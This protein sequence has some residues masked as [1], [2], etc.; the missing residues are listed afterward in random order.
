MP[1]TKF[2]LEVKRGSACVKIYRT[3][4]KGC[5]SFTLSYWVDGKRNRIAFADFDKAKS[6]ASA[7]ADRLSKG[8]F[9]NAT[10]NREDRATYARAIEILKLTGIPLELAVA[11]FV[12]AS[13]ALSGRPLIDAARFY[14]RRH[15]AQMPRRTVSETI[16]EMIVAKTQDGLSYLAINDLKKLRILA[17]DFQ[18]QISDLS[19]A[20]VDEWLRERDLAGRT[21]NNYRDLV[22]TMFN[23]AKRKK[24]L[25]FDHN[26]IDAVSIAKEGAT[27]IE[28]FSPAEM[29]MILS[30]AEPHLVPFLALGAFAGVRHWEITRLDWVDVK[31]AENHVEIKKGK[32]KTRNRRLVPIQDNLRKWLEPHTKQSGPICTYKNMSEEVMYLT[33]T[34]AE[35][36]KKFAWRHNALRHSFISYRMAILKDEN[37]VALESGNSPK[38]IFESYRELVSEK[39]ARTWF[40]IEPKQGNNIVDFAQAS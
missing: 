26:E 27:E 7:I 30:C 39:D 8:E 21:R 3:P 34:I 37:K 11:Q 18:I 5:E 28:I 9:D 32:A 35:Q 14:A 33:A 4:T 19:G 15:P 20:D 2:P 38:V 40:S 25:P 36:E 16:E 31:F 29:A 24:Y 17:E 22:R 6:E 23:F 12:E 1:V 10:L 13:S